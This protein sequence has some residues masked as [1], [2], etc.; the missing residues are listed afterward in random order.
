MPIRNASKAIVLDNGKI[1][2]NVNEDDRVGR[3]YSFPGGGQET[4]ETMEENVVREILEE[5]GYTASVVR[6]AALHEEIW[7]SEERRRDH[8]GYSH[9]V[10]HFFICK[11]DGNPPVEPVEPDSSQLGLEWVELEKLSGLPLYPECMRE[12]VQKI[13]SSGE[14]VYFPAE[15]IK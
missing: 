4:Y 5:T 1:L 13:F 14:I 3:Y 7:T 10:T 9:I 6:F 12:G 2:L 11:T 8:P 15:Y